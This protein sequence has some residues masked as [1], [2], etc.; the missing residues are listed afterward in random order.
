MIKNFLFIFLLIIIPVSV[1]LFFNKSPA[2]KKVHFHAGFLVYQNNI[3]LDFSGNKYMDYSNC[4]LHPDNLTPAE[5]QQEKAHLHD[6]VGN[7]VH[8][9]IAGAKWHDLF[10]NLKFPFPKNQKITGFLGGKE[11]KN[12]LNEEIK[13]YES[14][15]I[16][17]GDYSKVNLKKYV[18]GAEIKKVEKTSE[19]CGS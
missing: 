12:I 19:L 6:N 11:D 18:S 3:L 4:K 5:F 10:S 13:P 16:A 15:I 1:Y 8:V 14:V 2:P 9:H 17:I 7:V